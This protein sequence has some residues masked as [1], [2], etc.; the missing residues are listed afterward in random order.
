MKVL[1]LI[2]GLVIGGGVGWFTA[3][4]PAVD[5]KIGDVSVEVNRDADGGSLTATGADGD[6]FTIGAGEESILDDHYTRTGVFAAG[7]GVIG[8]ILGFLFGRR[9]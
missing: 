2:L 6:G 8:L 7:G 5:L 3:P 1:L 4:K 9:R